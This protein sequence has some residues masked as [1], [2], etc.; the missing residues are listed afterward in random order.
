MLTGSLI[1]FLRQTPKMFWAWLTRR[2]S[3]EIEVLNSDPLFD[4]VTYW[5]D[6]QPYAKRSRR[7]SATTKTRM[8][9]DSAGREGCP[10]ESA[11]TSAI[12]LPRILLSP[13]PGSHIFRH[14]KNIIWLQRTR[15]KGGA[16]ASS[17][18][19]MTALLK[20]ES[21]TIVTLGRDQAPIR[22]L[23][24]EI[25]AFGARPRLGVRLF[26][27]SFGYWQSRGV[28]KPRK[29]DT[30]ILPDGIAEALLADAQ[31]FLS[32]GDWYRSVGIPWHRGYLFYG[33]P[34]S[35]KT[36]VAAAL[37][38]ELRLDLY[39][40]N[41]GAPGMDDDRLS[42]LMGEIRPGSI[43]LMEDVDCTF[44]AREGSDSASRRV[45]LAGLLNCLD[46]VQSQ[47]G[48]MIFM[49]TN[50]RERLDTALLR[51]GRADVQVEFGTATASQVYRLKCHIAPRYSKPL[52]GLVGRSMAEV[53]QEF[54]VHSGP[55]ANTAGNVPTAMASYFVP[56][57]KDRFSAR[58]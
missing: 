6:S 49:T 48:S 53:Q 36:S 26:T 14:R 25:V 46:G 4:Y 28:L 9:T 54:V 35:G 19:W 41:I 37:A 24:D 42:Q 31:A 57:S 8:E 2:L 45:T 44:P 33:I 34:G 40:L 58:T 39:L 47:E 13:A 10:A 38:G 51:P 55:M 11:N 29:L 22:S 15:D 7:L 21:Y 3:V 16:P 18:N 1:A 32:S 43:V 50:F 12:T 20:H 5:L 23:L 17:G 27:A 30:V 52:S 56:E